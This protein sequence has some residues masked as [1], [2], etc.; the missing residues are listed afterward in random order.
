MKM[1]QMLL[2]IKRNVDIDGNYGSS[3]LFVAVFRGQTDM[4]RLL[5][6]RGG[7]VNFK[8]AGYDTPLH[9]AIRE[10]HLEIVELLLE[11]KAEVNFVPPFI[12]YTPLQSAI[13]DGN[14]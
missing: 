10:K 13:L 7:N 8:S 9:W 12:G 5:L 1:F 4:V 11:H 3:P 14:K 6:Q 2:E